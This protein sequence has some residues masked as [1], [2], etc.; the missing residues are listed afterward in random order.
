MLIDEGTCI[1][2]RTCIAACPFG[3]PTVIQETRK[4][5]KCD[6]CHG[7]PQCVEFCAS[8]AIQFLPANKAVLLKKRSA[9]LKLGELM[10]TIAS[11]AA[12]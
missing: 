10:T 3:A 11:Q 4:V 5:I 12:G 2:C 9:A 1:G 8:K 6:L 7:D